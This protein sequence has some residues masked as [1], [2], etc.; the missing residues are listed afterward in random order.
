MI[1][2]VGLFA[3]FHHATMDAAGARTEA[4]MPIRLSEVLQ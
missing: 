3:C 1:F 4:A 2:P